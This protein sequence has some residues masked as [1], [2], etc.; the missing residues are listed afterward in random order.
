MSLKDDIFAAD[1][2][3]YEVVPT[4]EWAPK[5]TSVVVRSLMSDERDE[6]ETSILVEKKERRR[7]GR[8]R[9]V[10]KVD[11]K[12]LR[13]KLAVRAICVAEGNPS[14]VF[15]NADADI[16]TKKSAAALDRIY[17]AAQKLC[18]FTEDD[19]DELGKE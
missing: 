2:V 10:H 18:G 8:T 14:R 19:A 9:T 15:T 17:E 12:A 7:S 11:S 16:L 3:R 1:D 6:F 4:P 13:A 5:V